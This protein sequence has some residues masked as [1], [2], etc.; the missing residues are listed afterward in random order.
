MDVPDPL[1]EYRQKAV[2]KASTYN[3]VVSNSTIRIIL[4]TSGSKL[5]KKYTF[6]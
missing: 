4:F 3:K 1:K 2:G 5:W 6:T